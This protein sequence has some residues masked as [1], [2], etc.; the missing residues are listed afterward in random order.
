MDPVIGRCKQ[1]GQLRRA[2]GGPSASRRS[3]REGPRIAGRPCSGWR[4]SRKGGSH[5]APFRHGV[6]G[7]VASTGTVMIGM[8]AII[9]AF[10]LL[11]QA[12]VLD[13]QNEPGRP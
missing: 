5:R 6:A 3:G 2:A 11:L 10:Q 8:L 4:T 1:P 13:V 7:V 12:V 9:L